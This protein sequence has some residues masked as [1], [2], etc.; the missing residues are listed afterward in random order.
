MTAANAIAL[1]EE[2]RLTFGDEAASRLTA[3]LAAEMR[4]AAEADLRHAA[5]LEAWANESAGVNS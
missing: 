3:K 2:A 4:E 5:A 1:V